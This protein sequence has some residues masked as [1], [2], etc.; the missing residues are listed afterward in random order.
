MGLFI[1]L[2]NFRPPPIGEK[3][4]PRLQERTYLPIFKL[5]LNEIEQT[6]LPCKNTKDRKFRPSLSKNAPEMNLKHWR[7]LFLDWGCLL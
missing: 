2:S 1:G 4:T 7:P 3:T 5:V 6:I